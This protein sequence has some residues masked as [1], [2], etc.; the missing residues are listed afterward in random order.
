[1]TEIASNYTLMVADYF[2]Q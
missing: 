1:V 2:I